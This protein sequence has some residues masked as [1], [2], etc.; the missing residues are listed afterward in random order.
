[1]DDKSGA[2]L[3]RIKT[4]QRLT[5][6]FALAMTSRID[7]TKGGLSVQ[8]IMRRAMVSLLIYCVF[9]MRDEPVLCTLFITVEVEHI[10]HSVSVLNAVER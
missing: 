6:T 4:P 2:L 5:L 3:R 7:D 1:M 10:W 9:D 8:L